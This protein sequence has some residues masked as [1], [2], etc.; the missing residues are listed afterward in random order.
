MRLRSLKNQLL[1]HT[2]FVASQP[3]HSYHESTLLKYGL[4]L[5]IYLALVVHKRWSMPKGICNF[6][7]AYAHGLAEDEA[8]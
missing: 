1:S 4:A 7:F 8:A 6:S 3:S 2:K 5:Y